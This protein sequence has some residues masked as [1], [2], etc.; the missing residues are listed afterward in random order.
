MSLSCPL[1]G[2]C[3]ALDPLDLIQCDLCSEWIHKKCAAS[4]DVDLAEELKQKK[5]SKSTVFWR[6]YWCKKAWLDLRSGINGRNL[7]NDVSLVPKAEVDAMRAEVT[8]LQMKVADLTA[9]VEKLSMKGCDMLSVKGDDAKKSISSTPGRV[10]RAVEAMESR[11]PEVW[12]TKAPETPTTVADS[13]IE[14]KSR[15]KSRKE[16]RMAVVEPIPVDDSE[17]LVVGDS[18]MSGVLQRERSTRVHAFPGSTTESIGK[19]MAVTKLPPGKVGPKVVT[20]HVGGNNLSNGQDLDY[21]LGDH[22]NL[23]D[24]TKNTFPNA[25]IIVLG[26]LFRRGIARQTVINFNKS[27]SWMCDCLDVT[28]IDA[29]A[30]LNH[31]HYTNDGV[32]LTFRGRSILTEVLKNYLRLLAQKK[33]RG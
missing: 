3:L 8:A 17:N 4:M 11:T 14:V 18:L 5:R 10:K 33:I 19:K 21:A 13:F 22:W 27:L 23:V 24:E 16:R 2:D 6:C 1:G 31:S 20:L 7:V 26:I 28:F 30:Y 29:S 9:L 15:R 12:S 32:H 25:K